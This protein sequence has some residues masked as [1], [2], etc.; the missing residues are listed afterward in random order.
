MCHRAWSLQSCRLGVNTAAV[1]LYIEQAPPRNGNSDLG[2]A[3]DRS[4]K[5]AW[6]ARTQWVNCAKKQRIRTCAGGPSTPKGGHVPRARGLAGLKSER[7]GEVRNKTSQTATAQHQQ[8]SS[9]SYT[10]THP[11]SAWRTLND[12]A[13]FG[14]QSLVYKNAGRQISLPRGQK[15]FNRDTT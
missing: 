7:L 10:S 8:Q 3:P 13:K 12:M 1:A 15:G 4:A 14:L 11:S 6:V 2:C 9:K 5:V